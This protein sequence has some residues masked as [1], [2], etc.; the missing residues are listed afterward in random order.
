[1]GSRAPLNV[2]DSNQMEF[3]TSDAFS[4]SGRIH[5]SPPHSEDANFR[6]AHN[7]YCGSAVDDFG[8]S[9]SAFRILHHLKRRAGKNPFAKCGIDGIAKICRVN[10]K[11]VI[12]AVRELES[13]KPLRCERGT[14]RRTRYQITSP[15]EWVVANRSLKRTGLNNEIQP[16]RSLKRTTPFPKTDRLPVPKTD[17]TSPKEGTKGITLKEHKEGSSLKASAH[18]TSGSIHT[19]S[20]PVKSKRSKLSAVATKE[21]IG[22]LQKQYAGLDVISIFP[23]AQKVCA[24]LHPNGGPMRLKFFVEYLDREPLTVVAKAEDDVRKAREQAEARQHRRESKRVT[25]EEEEPEQF[26]IEERKL[27]APL[28]PDPES[29]TNFERNQKRREAEHRAREFDAEANALTPEQRLAKLSKMKQT[30]SSDQAR[31][32]GLKQFGAQQ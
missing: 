16:N 19:P 30:I 14:G 7:I 2:K 8:L 26:D 20:G 4:Q 17:H 1:M 9:P 32:E 27:K 11:T 24:E 23:E 3:T 28:P 6:K 31:A 12:A 25:P 5:S 18:S 13:H 15:E 10:R 22:E 29:N 21:N